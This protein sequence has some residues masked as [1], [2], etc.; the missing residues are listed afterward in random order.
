MRVRLNT[1]IFDE[2]CQGV[3]DERTTSLFLQA[4]EDLHQRDM[5]AVRRGDYEALV[6]LWTDD[7]VS[8]APDR[9]AIKGKEAMRKELMKRKEENS[10]MEVLDYV[11][12]FDEVKILGD[13]AY[14][15]GTYRGTV[16]WSGR[17]EETRQEGKL[18]R[19][20]KRHDDGSWKVAR[21][22]YN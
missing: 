17:E 3:F 9:P 15:W 2:L 16:R 18:M 19:I 13:V 21:T 4:I 14:E 1:A 20:L 11:L 8:L 6:G 12:S 10:G 22:I 5:E 7:I